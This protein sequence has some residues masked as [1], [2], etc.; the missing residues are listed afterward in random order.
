MQQLRQRLGL[1]LSCFQV[2]VNLQEWHDGL[3]ED[4]GV[5]FVEVVLDVVELQ[6]GMLS[7]QNPGK[8]GTTQQDGT[9]AH[10]KTHSGPRGG[11]AQEP[12]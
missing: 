3:G 4:F 11:R 5:A 7:N 8:D 6:G 9:I 2:F 1:N 10:N 12:H